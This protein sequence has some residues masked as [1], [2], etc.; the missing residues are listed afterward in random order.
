MAGQEWWDPAQEKK[1]GPMKVKSQFLHCGCGLSA[2]G[3][4][5]IYQANSLVV[6]RATDI[7]SGGSSPAGC[8]SQ[9]RPLPHRPPGRLHLANTIKIV[10]PCK[11]RDK[12][13]IRTIRGHPE[14]A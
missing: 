1:G 8:S 5:N 2:I 13:T 10:F 6:I 9:E 11:G 7:F 14:G 4:T 12:K 3:T